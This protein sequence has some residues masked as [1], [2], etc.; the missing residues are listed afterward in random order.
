MWLRVGLVVSVVL[1]ISPSAQQPAP[2]ATRSVTGVVRDAVTRAPIPGAKVKVGPFN[3][4]WCDPCSAIEGVAGVVTDSAGRFTI[5]DLPGTFVLEAGQTGYAV[6]GFGVRRPVGRAARIDLAPGQRLGDLEIVMFREAVITGRVTDETGA[7]VAG[8]TVELSRIDARGRWT[9]PSWTSGERDPHRPVTDAMGYYTAHV[10]PDEYA[11]AAIRG[12]VP[13][14]HPAEDHLQAAALVTVDPGEVLTGVDVHLPLRRVGSARGHFQ[15]PADPQAMRLN[16]SIRLR[17]PRFEIRGRFDGDSFV[18]DNVPYGEYSLEVR[19]S[20]FTDVTAQSSPLLEWWARVPVRVDAA[21]VEVG[22][23]PPQPALVMS[24]VVT[25][26]AAKTAEDWSRSG[27]QLLSPDEDEPCGRIRAR[28]SVAAGGEFLLKTMPGEFRLCAWPHKRVGFGEATLIGKDIVDLPFT[29]RGDVGGLQVVHPVEPARL[30]GIVRGRDGRPVREGWV[31][32]FPADRRYWAH[33]VAEGGRFAA[34][35]VSVAGAF[36]INTL[37][38][39]EYF[40]AAVDDLS[41]DGWPMESWLAS[42][43]K[44]AVRATLGR[45]QTRTLS[46]VRLRTIPVE[47][48]PVREHR[49]VIDAQWPSFAGLWSLDDGTMVVEIR[50]PGEPNLRR[51]VYRRER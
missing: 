38:P 5:D 50:R 12:G 10:A 39:A 49:R 24:G 17:N 7:P 36:E 34:A 26:P 1:A 40:V 15:I 22:D 8:L 30:R 18:V 29:V 27:V 20:R 32:V 33:A 25:S 42:A 9:L 41:I 4:D 21:T 51:T 44:G 2:T 16:T 45:S 13:A 3:H 19:S 48:A 6:G 11:V 35:R 23:V 47:R 14:F 46:P 28:N 43:A 31:V 37:L